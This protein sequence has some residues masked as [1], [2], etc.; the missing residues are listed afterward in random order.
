MK[1][2]LNV[3]NNEILKFFLKKE[4]YFTLELPPY[5]D[6][7]KIIDDIYSRVKGKQLSDVCNKNVKNKPD[8]PKN[9]EG[10]NYKLINNKNG[11]Y[12]WRPF[13][14]I[15]P[16]LYA[17]L[18]QQICEKDNWNIIKGRFK[19][20]SKNKRIICCSIPLYYSNKKNI[21]LNWWNNFEQKSISNSLK[22]KYMAC[23]DITNCYSSIYTHSIPWA[24]HTKEIAKQ[25]RDDKIIGNII[26]QKLQN[27]NY[28]Q[29]NGIPQ[30][31][32]L[33]DLLAEIVLGYADELLLKK[34][35]DNKVND[36]QILRYRDDYKIF[37]NDLTI[38]EKILKALTEVLGELN[39]KLNN[40][41][42]C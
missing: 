33:M 4:N 5:F 29:T 31:S 8:Y 6:F 15:H 2:I 3:N 9:Y 18:V 24:I 36:Y 13:E 38:I 41:K 14:L 42:T 23:T 22:Y 37:A 19:D 21:V 11:K 20:F 39:L 10:V 16:V 30:G 17:D 27:M 28:G 35:E 40:N 34:L 1:S 7:Q 32:T 25:D 26:D 12:D